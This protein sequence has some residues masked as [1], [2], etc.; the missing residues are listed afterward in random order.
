MTAR[1]D[2]T[3]RSPDQG[4]PVRDAKRP[5][6][7]RLLDARA[8]R[9]PDARAAVTAALIE[10]VLPLAAGF[11]GPVACYLPVGAEP[12]ALGSGTVALPDALLAAGHEVLLPIVPAEPGPLDWTRYSGREDLAPGPLGIREPAGERLGPGAISSAA[13]VLVPALAVDRRGL[14][15]G[16]GGGYYDRTLPLVGPGTTTAVPLHDDEFL[17]EIPAEPHDVAVGAVVLPGTGVVHVSSR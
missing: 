13:L 8:E 14:R 9:S 2:G 1:A 10:H 5:L 15:L 6:R 16:R 17:D 7:R 4:V 12:G 3:D 11:R